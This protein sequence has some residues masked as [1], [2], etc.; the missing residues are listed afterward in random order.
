M[1][2]TLFIS[3]I[4]LAFTGCTQIKIQP[5]I[6]TSIQKPI[7]KPEIKPMPTK[8][9]EEK[10]MD[11]EDIAIKEES[12]YD[13][14][15]TG[16]W[17]AQATSTPKQRKLYLKRVKESIQGELEV[18]LISEVTGNVFEVY[19][20]KVILYIKDGYSQGTISSLDYKEKVILYR[21]S[22]DSFR[23]I[24]D[25][26]D[27]KFF[28]TKEI[29]F[30][31]YNKKPEVKQII[32]YETKDGLVLDKTN[33]IIWQDNKSTQVLRS[34]WQ[35]AKD[36]CKL[37][38][39]KGYIDWKLP[40]RDQ[41]KSTIDKKAHS[42]DPSFNHNKQ[43]QYWSSS[44]SFDLYEESWFIDYDRG[45]MTVDPKTTRKYIRCIKNL[46]PLTN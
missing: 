23:I 30:I 42:I 25:E 34:T 35:S 5:Q 32:E 43:K 9:V 45:I 31:K 4:L 33:N 12:K 6:K 17:L 3:I 8:V 37:L 38:R 29:R 40:S 10:K 7:I 39:Y 19:T 44:E 41:L 36:Y 27:S 46:N 1:K 21:D 2:I 28:D 26:K 24:I 22:E 14:N 13:Y 16:T 11:I 20:H 18:S 15:Y